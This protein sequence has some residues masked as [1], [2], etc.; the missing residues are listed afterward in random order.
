MS[1]VNWQVFLKT[2]RRVLGK[3]AWEP[4]LSE[5]WCAFT[6]FNSLQHGIHYWSCGFPEETEI[7]DTHTVDGGLWRQPFAYDD[8][9]HVI[10]P[11][12]FYWETTDGKFDSGYK[13]QDLDAV[14]KELSELGIQH[15]KTDL[16]L[17]VKLY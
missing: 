4:S 14:S 12:T 11:K 5:S 15:R 16:L 6:T 10:V 1:D 9:A 2:C 13:E 3:G 8:L 17:E 7:L